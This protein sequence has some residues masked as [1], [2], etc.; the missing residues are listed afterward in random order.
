MPDKASK[1]PS[2]DKPCGPLSPF[3]GHVSTW[4][5][6]R[7]RFWLLSPA[8]FDGAMMTHASDRGVFCASNPPNDKQDDGG[9][10]NREPLIA[11]AAILILLILI[12]VMVAILAVALLFFAIALLLSE[13]SVQLDSHDSHQSA[14]WES[15]A[16]SGHDSRLPHTLSNTRFQEGCSVDFTIYLDHAKT[17]QVRYAKESK[18]GR[19]WH[20]IMRGL[21]DTSYSYGFSEYLDVQTLREC[22]SRVNHRLIIAILIVKARKAGLQQ[23]AE[24]YLEPLT[25]ALDSNCLTIDEG[26]MIPVVMSPS[27]RSVNLLKSPSAPFRMGISRSCHF[28]V[29]FM[30]FY[31]DVYLPIEAS[32]SISKYS[33]CSPCC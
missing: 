10:S 33:R 27:F 20:I 24:V 28:L 9:A 5:V 30:Q 7:N 26:I 16:P 11:P 13:S 4:L 18:L 25:F 23:V 29:L 17:Q 8:R 14:T 12:G 21:T 3:S 1:S 32:G 6:E 31:V 15:S 19:Y 2:Q 22:A